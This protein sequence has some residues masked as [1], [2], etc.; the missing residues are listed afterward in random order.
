KPSPIINPKV[1][2]VILAMWISGCTR[3]EVSPSQVVQR[4]HN[5]P[6]NAR[7]EMQMG[8][9]AEAGGADGADHLPLAD[10][11][12]DGHADARLM[13]VAGGQ[14]R[15]VLDARVVAVAADPARDRDA[16]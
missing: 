10:V 13:P 4:V 1:C 6:V 11:L 15:G 2:S 16:A 5:G 9:G 3:D 12:A 7:F 14:R 8:S